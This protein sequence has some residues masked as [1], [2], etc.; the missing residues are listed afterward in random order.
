M[1]EC[2]GIIAGTGN[3][4][5][6]LIEAC[7]R[8]QRPFFILAFE[9]QTD[10]TLLHGR[11]H[12]WTTL[13]KVGHS[14]QLLRTAQVTQIVMAGHFNRP[15]WHELNPDLIGA[16]WLST[17]MRK[18]FG[19]DSVLRQII[20][21]LEQEGFTIISPESIISTTLFIPKGVA[22]QVHPSEL[23]WQDIL[24]GQDI[25]NNLSALDIGQSIVIQQGLTLGVEAIEGTDALIKRCSHY[26]RPG[27]PPVLVKM[28][29]QN[30]ETR[31]DRATVGIDTLNNLIKYGFSG[32]AIEADS[33]L[34][35]DQPLL[36]HQADQAG[37]FVV[38]I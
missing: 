17:L 3:L 2:L 14:L 1:S 23:A 4:I 7:E 25:L 20:R 9:G 22:G 37:L 15:S 28:C 36:I 32:L 31:V 12:G 13:G 34:V 24:R 27:P 35:L 10:P 29:K 26:K 33:V 21:L 8:Q 5:H 11:P 16:K 30:Q 18:A 6:Q 38:G 19:D